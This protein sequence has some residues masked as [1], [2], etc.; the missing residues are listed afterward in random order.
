[1]LIMFKRT[2]PCIRP[3]ADYGTLLYRRILLLPFWPFTQFAKTELVECFPMQF[4][5]EKDF[6]KK[7]R[8]G[9]INVGAVWDAH[10]YEDCRK[11]PDGKSLVVMTPQGVWYIDESSFTCTRPHDDEH[12][13]WV[14]H[15][16]VEEGNLQVDKQG[17]TCESGAG[18][19]RI[20]D[21]KNK[22]SLYHARLMRNS[23]IRII[24]F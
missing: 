7:L 3:F 10:W 11:G 8:R 4:K 5:N 18:S 23:L 6:L 19:I 21:R 14:R 12:R 20:V 9:K 1:M 24:F 2:P 22:K 15:G 17:D 13:C 16:S